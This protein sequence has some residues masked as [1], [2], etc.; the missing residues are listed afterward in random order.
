[1]T[2]ALAHIGV[3][4]LHITL[5]AYQ[6]GRESVEKNKEKKEKKERKRR[7]RKGERMRRGRKIRRLLPL[8]YRHFDSQ[9]SSG[10]EL[11]S[12]YSMRAT[13]QE[14]GTLPTLAYFHLKGYFAVFFALKGCLAR[15][16]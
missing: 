6:W 3:H 16:L 14:V 9:N 8:I 4:I 15:F 11:K 10:R 2:C 13:F 1:M 7:R 12:V 5:S